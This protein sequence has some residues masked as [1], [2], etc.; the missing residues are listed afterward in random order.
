MV[1]NSIRRLARGGVRR[2]VSLVVVTVVVLSW[3]ATA[4]AAAELKEAR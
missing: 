4:S 2:L 1:P 3:A